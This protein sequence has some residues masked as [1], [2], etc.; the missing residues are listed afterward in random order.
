VNSSA[1]Q[2]AEL[3]AASAAECSPPP[4]AGT[5]SGGVVPRNAVGGPA[6]AAPRAVAFEDLASLVGE[7]LG[8]SSWHE[9]TQAKIDAF[10]ELTGDQQWIHVD[11]VRAADG[12]FGGTIA[13]GYLT[14]CLS[15]AITFEVAEFTGIAAAVNY[16]LDKVRFTAP[17]PSGSRVRG[18]V[19]VLSVRRRGR[20]FTEL[21]LELVYE[22][23]GSDTSP[24][25]ARVV[26]LLQPA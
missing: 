9:I 7:T 25:T 10:A 23:E 20:Q 26:T 11:P 18:R 3:G 4:G 15:T 14:L 21:V 5:A 1:Q 17:V 19:N 6:G 8:T 12:P 2:L 24:C 16:G 13:H 22:L